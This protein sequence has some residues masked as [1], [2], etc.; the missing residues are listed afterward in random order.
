MATIVQFNQFGDA[1]D[2]DLGNVGLKRF[3]HFGIGLANARKDDL[4]RVHARTQRTAHFTDRNN[5][6]PGPKIGKCL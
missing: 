1:F 2:I 6:R 5:I 4:G 3:A